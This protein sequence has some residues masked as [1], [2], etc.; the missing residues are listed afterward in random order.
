[1]A[2]PFTI[3]GEEI[4]NLSDALA[5]CKEIWAEYK[6]PAVAEQIAAAEAKGSGVADVDLPDLSEAAEGEEE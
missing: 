4:D 6:A 2:A 1:M 3:N 5:R